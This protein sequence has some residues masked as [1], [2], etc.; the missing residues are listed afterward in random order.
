MFYVYRGKYMWL[1]AIETETANKCRWLE[2]SKCQNDSRLSC[3]W[4]ETN[5]FAS[6]RMKTRRGMCQ[7]KN[8]R[9]AVPLPCHSWYSSTHFFLVRPPLYH[10]YH[11]MHN[12]KKHS[13]S[14]TTYCLPQWATSKYS[15]SCTFS[16]ANFVEM[17]S[18]FAICFNGTLVM[19][20]F[21]GGI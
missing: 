7:N 3:C 14:C 15:H 4:R 20:L 12:M 8:K 19:V 1:R 18:R 10:F 13:N 5:G 21:E 9:A 6:W 17:C 11:I 2:T 16:S